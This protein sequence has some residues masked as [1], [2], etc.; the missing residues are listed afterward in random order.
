VGRDL[1]IIEKD[2]TGSKDPLRNSVFEKRKRRK[3]RRMIKRKRKNRC[4]KGRKKSTN[5]LTNKFSNLEVKMVLNQTC[6][7]F[8]TYHYP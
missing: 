6:S 7:N 4:I 2:F 1:K 8:T 5:Q 3:R